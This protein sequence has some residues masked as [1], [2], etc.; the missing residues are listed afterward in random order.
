MAAA[1]PNTTTI[2]QLLRS[3][4]GLRPHLRAELEGGTFPKHSKFSIH[5]DRCEEWYD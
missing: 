4:L 2:L 5:D 1:D 3:D